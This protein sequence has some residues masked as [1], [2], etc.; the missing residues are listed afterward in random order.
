MNLHVPLVHHQTEMEMS[1]VV[2][3]LA[4]S[5]SSGLPCP[6]EM[7]QLVELQAMLGHPPLRCP[8]IPHLPLLV[9]QHS[10]QVLYW[11]GLHCLDQR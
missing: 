11:Q 10:D 2:L 5:S 3:N 4:V 7:E 8:Q 1:L 6:A 9:P